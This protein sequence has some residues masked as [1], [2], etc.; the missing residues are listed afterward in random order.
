M[1][2]LGVCGVY[3]FQIKK[4]YDNHLEIQNYE[5]FIGYGGHGMLTPFYSEYGHSYLMFVT[6]RWECLRV[7]F[8][9][10]PYLK[11]K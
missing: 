2:I 6:K 4:A 3:H 9:Q 1:F 10:S 5:R 11:L 7:L 8:Y